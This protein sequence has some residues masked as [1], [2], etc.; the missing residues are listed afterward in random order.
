MVEELT[1]KTRHNAE[2]LSRFDLPVYVTTPDLLA[3]VPQATWIPLVVDVDAWS[4]EDPVLVRRRPVVFHAPSAR[5]SKGTDL[6]LPDLEEMDAR[7]VIE[8]RVAEGVPWA[9]MR[10]LVRSS[11]IVVDQVAVGSYGTLACEAMAAGKPVIAHLT[12]TV[13]TAFDGPPP[14]VNT[15]PTGVRATVEQLLDDRDG[16]AEIGVRARDFARRVHDGRRSAALL[17][18]FLF[19]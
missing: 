6:F 3:D 18:P 14:L 17:R 13:I 4:C 11:D 19:S 1:E 8:L 2:I 16:A 9:E 7:G 15:E 5:W 12:E 10:E